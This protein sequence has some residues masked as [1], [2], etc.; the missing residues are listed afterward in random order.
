[1]PADAHILLDQSAAPDLLAALQRIEKKQDLPTPTAIPSP[2]PT[3]IPFPTRTLSAGETDLES[4]TTVETGAAVVETPP[5]VA[6]R[7]AAQTPSPTATVQPAVPARPEG[8]IVFATQDETGKYDLWMSD[9]QGDNRSWIASDMHQPDVRADGLIV[10]NGT[11]ATTHA[12][13]LT[14]RADG[15][16]VREVSLYDNDVNP[17]WATDGARLLYV[18]EQV[19]ELDVQDELSKNARRLPIYFE[20]N[21]LLGRHPDWLDEDHVVYQ[22]CDVWQRGTM[23]GLYV[24]QIS[25]GAAPWRVVNDTRATAPAANAGRIAYM[26]DQDG[27]WD[28]H[29]LDGK[30]PTPL[31][32]TDD[33]AA[34]GL[35]AWSPDGEWLA[36]LSNRGGSWAV[37]AM[38]PQAGEQPVKLSELEG[39]PGAVWVNE[40]IAWLP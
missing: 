36:F 22:G 17:R 18:N 31:R 21:P 1:M 32:L 26:T 15:S 7:D 37:W 28:I 9:T 11:G 13:L 39:N 8:R 33:P 24:A 6:T 16:D 19:G 14:L 29:L 3:I 10:A 4:A 2:S 23:C 38:R 5:L 35:P 25:G 12:T 40:Q 20:I 34:D 30:Q 27:S